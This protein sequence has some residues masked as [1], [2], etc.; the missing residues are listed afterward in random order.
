MSQLGRALYNGRF[1][2]FKM[3]L[4]SPWLEALIVS[5]VGVM[6]APLPSLSWGGGGVG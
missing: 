4:D 3:E 6:P 1:G 2:R 5:G